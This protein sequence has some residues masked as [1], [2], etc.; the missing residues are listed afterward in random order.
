MEPHRKQKEGTFPCPLQLFRTSEIRGTE[1]STS[2]YSA[3][4]WTADLAAALR[5]AKNARPSSPEPSNSRDEGSG[6]STRDV[7]GAK[8]SPKVVLVL[9]LVLLRLQST[10]VGLSPVSVRVP[11]PL[12]SR[13]VELS[14][15][16]VRLLMVNVIPSLVENNS[17]PRAVENTRG[18]V[19]KAT[20]SPTTAVS[21]PLVAGEGATVAFPDICENE[22]SVKLHVSVEPL[23]AR[24]PVIGVA[25]APDV[26]TTAEAIATKANANFF[27]VP[28]TVSPSRAL[29]S[30]L[31]L[32]RST[33]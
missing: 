27:I 20:L 23:T 29:Y 31:F 21:E 33:V 19:V 15:S 2:G 16:T 14:R 24:V 28:P 7:I 22:I 18:L 26:N 4:S 32:L 5:D 3:P 10:S 17:F 25:E 9:V 11:V 8:S 12:R 1:W 30:C 6:V 13:K